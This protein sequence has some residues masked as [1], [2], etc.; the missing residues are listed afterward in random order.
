MTYSCAATPRLP[1]AIVAVADREVRLNNVEAAQ[2]SEIDW[3]TGGVV[4][5]SDDYA[6]VLV[7]DGRAMAMPHD[8]YEYIRFEA[9]RRNVSMVHIYREEMKAREE[10]KTIVLP[11][12]RLE[13]AAQRDYSSHPWLQGEEDCPF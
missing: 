1:A 7:I 6:A 5:Q 4:S 13:R 2:C 11:R 9:Q 8:L 10:L 3:C 12:D